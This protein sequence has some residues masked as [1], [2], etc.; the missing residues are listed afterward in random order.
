LVPS[1]ELERLKLA[2][3]SA[4]AHLGAT[5]ARLSYAKTTEKL[6][7]GVKPEERLQMLHE[8]AMRLFFD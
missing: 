3:A 5:T 6:K 7:L 4:N 1:L 2:S 8:S